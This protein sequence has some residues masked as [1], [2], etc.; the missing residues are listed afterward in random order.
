MPNCW[1]ISTFLWL[2]GNIISFM[3]YLAPLWVHICYFFFPS[4]RQFPSYHLHSIFGLE[5][6]WACFI[7]LHHSPTFYR[8]YRIRST[9]GFQSVPY[10]VA[11]FSAML[12]IYYAIVKTDATLLI[13]IN[14]FG[15]FIETI[16]TAIY[17][18]YAPRSMRVLKYL[19]H[20]LLSSHR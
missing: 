13:T 14:S 18:I 12:W 8:V 1:M 10:V 19:G 6:D 3:V 16:Y 20:C 4:L 7:S 5:Y 11:L 17:L 9:E 15:C 2:A